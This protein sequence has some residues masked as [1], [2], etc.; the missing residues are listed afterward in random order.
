[1]EN[2]QW[3]VW[4]VFIQPKQGE[5]YTHVGNVHAPDPEMALQN[6]RDLYSRRGKLPE[7]GL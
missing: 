6:A 5:A 1:M 4:E 7:S 3:T 2:D